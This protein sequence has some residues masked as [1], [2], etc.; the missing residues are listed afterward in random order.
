MRLEYKQFDFEETLREIDS[1]V[2][3]ELE[4]LTPMNQF[5]P[6]HQNGGDIECAYAGAIAVCV[7]LSVYDNNYIAGLGKAY[8]LVKKVLLDILRGNPDCLDIICMGRTFCGIFNTLLK[9]NIDGL[10]DT[11]AK[12]NAALSVLD[13]KLSQKY[14][15]QVMGNCGCDFGELFRIRSYYKDNAEEKVFESWHGAPLNMAILYS[16][17][18]RM[19]DKNGTIISENVRSNIKDEYKAFFKSYDDTFS[20]YWT[21]LVDSKMFDWVK[22]NR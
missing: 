19:N 22:S 1:V 6:V 20:G 12:L 7:R 10:I 15:I 2:N 3:Q 17:H 9:S 14:K 18:T 16:E 8:E 11:L 4:D 5:L 13:I 21:S